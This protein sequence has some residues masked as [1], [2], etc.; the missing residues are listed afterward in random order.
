MAISN[1]ALFPQRPKARD[2]QVDP[3]PAVLMQRDGKLA[4]LKVVA[5]DGSSLTWWWS[6]EQLREFA[7]DAL[8]IVDDIEGAP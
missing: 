4:Q 2:R 7:Q 5:T 6:P 1:V 3:H 8:E